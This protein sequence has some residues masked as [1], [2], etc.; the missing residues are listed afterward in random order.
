LNGVIESKE[1]KVEP[2]VAIEKIATK[3]KLT[4]AEKNAIISAMMGDSTIQ[5]TEKDTLF[6]VSNGIT[7]AAKGM[8]IERGREM[9]KLGGDI[10]HLIKIVA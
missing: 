5:E 10:Q 8:G 4:D 6:Q 3:E 1:I 9:N 2:T 7:R